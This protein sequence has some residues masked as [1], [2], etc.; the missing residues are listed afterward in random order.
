VI[1]PYNSY[2]RWS[3]ARTDADVLIAVGANPR[4][5]ELLYRESAPVDYVRC[6]YCMSWRALMPI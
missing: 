1:S 6:E 5:L 4:D 2:Y 3:A